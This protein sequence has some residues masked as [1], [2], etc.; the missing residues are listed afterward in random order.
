MTESAPRARTRAPA[1]PRGERS[2]TAAAAL[3]DVRLLGRHQLAAVVATLVDFASMIA[4]VELAGAAP[5]YATLLSATAGGVTNFFLGRTW[6][7][8]ER[9][10]GTLAAQAA[11]Y[12]LACAGGALLNASLLGATLALA[13]APYVVARVVVSILVS[14]AYTYPMHTRFVFRVVDAE[15]EAAAGDSVPRG[16]GATGKDGAT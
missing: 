16:C 11:R 9:H 12:A 13:A 4:L 10:R 3:L 6:A 5:A 15:P 2:T 14:I 7:F 8:R 1:D